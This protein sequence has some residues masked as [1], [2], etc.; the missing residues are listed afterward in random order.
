MIAAVTNIIDEATRLRRKQEAKLSR[1]NNQLY[2][3]IDDL[4]KK[5]LR[6]DIGGLIYEA[7]TG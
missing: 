7:S 6:K 5:Q 3:E 4:D 2:K 1:E